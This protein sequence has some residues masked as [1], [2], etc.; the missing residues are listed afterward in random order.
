MRIPRGYRQREAA[1]YARNNR[2]LVGPEI[3]AQRAAALAVSAGLITADEIPTTVEVTAE[4]PVEAEV[5][6]EET[7]EI[8][9]EVVAEETPAPE[10]EAVADPVESVA[11]VPVEPVKNKGGRPKKA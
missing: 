11:A 10:V 9:T 5:A 2:R 6:T 8:V 4:V 1:G 7:T 3:R